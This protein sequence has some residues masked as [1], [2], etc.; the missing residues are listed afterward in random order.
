MNFFSKFFGGQLIDGLFDGQPIDYHNHKARALIKDLWYDTEKSELICGRNWS[1]ASEAIWRTP[2]N[3]FFLTTT[4]WDS[5]YNDKGQIHI[6][7]I[8]PEHVKRSI[9]RLDPKF[10]VQ[11][12]SS[13]IKEA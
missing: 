9:F 4:N 1:F 5:D 11:Y 10:Y 2:N 3:R 13:D 6:E 8:S 12:Y 7:D